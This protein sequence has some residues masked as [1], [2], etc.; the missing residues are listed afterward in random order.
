MIESMR[1][2]TISGSYDEQAMPNLDSEEIDFRAA[3]ES[4]D[5][6]RPLKRRDL[7]SLRLV[8]SHQV[9]TK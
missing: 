7:E 6:M 9:S 3:S 8:T 5:P 4:F 2:F 1:R